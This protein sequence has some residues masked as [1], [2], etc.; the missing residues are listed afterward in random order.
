MQLQAAGQA[1]AQ[2]RGG[3]SN[4]DLGDFKACRVV[5]FGLPLDRS[6]AATQRPGYRL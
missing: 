2:R 3:Q 6:S 1:E 4:L 5:D